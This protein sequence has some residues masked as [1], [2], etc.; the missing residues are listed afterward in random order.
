MQPLDDI[1]A[2]AKLPQALLRVGRQHPARWPGR[3]SQT[4]PLKVR[5]RP[6]RISRSGSPAASPVRPKIN[7]PIRRPR[8]PGK[9]LIEPCPAS[10]P[11]PPPQGLGAPRAL[12]AGRARA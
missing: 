4:Q 5:I 8:F 9:H 12:I 11:S 1:A 2:L 6:I 7:D 3:F 10:R